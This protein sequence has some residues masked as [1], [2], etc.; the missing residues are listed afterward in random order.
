MN[1]NLIAL[2]EAARQA[3]GRRL[4]QPLLDADGQLPV[5]LLDPASKKRS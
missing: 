4:I 3:L 1:K 5:L 2:V